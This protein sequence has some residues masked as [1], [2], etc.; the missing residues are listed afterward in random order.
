VKIIQVM[1]HL[2]DLP[3]VNAE[4]TGRIATAL[5]LI[6]QGMNFADVLHLADSGHCEELYTFD[7]RRFAQGA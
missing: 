7:D 1:D 2:L 4:E 5:G 6:G 3:N